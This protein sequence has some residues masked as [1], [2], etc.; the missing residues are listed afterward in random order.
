M[1]AP[2]W[3]IDALVAATGGRLV[4]SVGPE[5]GG[6]SIDS[7]TVEPGDAFFAIRGDARD[8]H[9][10]VAGALGRGAAVCVVAEE[11]LAELP[12][13]GRWLVVADVL[14][15][16]CDVARA[17]RARSS[18]RI[19][20]V[21]GSVGKTSTKEALRHVLAEQGATHAS[22]ASYNNHW[23]V[24]LT[25][26]RLPA[27]ARYGIFEIGMNHAGEITPLVSLVRP[28]VAIVTTVAPVHLEF[29]AD[30]D[31]IAEAKAEIFSGLE[32]GGAAVIDG[33]VEQTALL[34]ERARAV[35]ARVVRFGRD[36]ACEA[37]LVQQHLQPECSTV[38]ASIDGRTLTY[39]IGAPGRHVVKNSLAVLA[40][41]DL[42]GADLARAGLALAGMTPPKGRG[43]R[44]VL[45]LGHGEAMLIDESYNANPASM[46]AAIDLLGH[47][48]VGLKGRRIAV[49]GDMLELGSR[50][51]KLHA[52]LAS[53]L[54]EAR[55]DRCYLAG[56]LM[57]AL[58]R[59][60]P[61]EMQGAHADTSRE[62]E[63]AVLAA[64]QPGDAIMVKGSNGSR[65]GPIVEALKRRWDCTRAK[66]DDL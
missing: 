32:P 43:L 48:D 63:A 21:T 22:F 30:V 35:G 1:T 55:I 12:A 8:G 18:A 29:F 26:A 13:D 27:D 38:I 3:T 25:L 16:L 58:W 5:V 33:D 34:V 39:K 37:R 47:A 11:K 10:F 24:P 62:I 40:A 52:E 65:M 61:P 15:A 6:V 60:L 2:L 17:A 44:H 49:L 53:A 7:R 19:V 59:E 51:E 57:Y 41:A 9:E 46:R 54:V 20:A 50:G 56:P 36:A 31:A 28:H 42:V 45:H 4:G 23:G 14:G 66:S 64:V